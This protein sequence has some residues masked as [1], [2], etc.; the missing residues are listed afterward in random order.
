MPFKLK[1]AVLAAVTVLAGLL[2]AAPAIAAPP[3]PLGSMPTGT[4][5][6]H[7]TAGRGLGISLDAFGLTPGSAH[8]VTL[9]MAPCSATTGGAGVH[10]V[11]ANG[12]GQLQSAFR[13]SGRK[14][15]G[16]QSVSLLLGTPGASGGGVSPSKIVACANI[17]QPLQGF[18]QLPL[19][20]KLGWASQLS[21]SFTVTYDAPA[22]TLT[23][24]IDARGF[25]PGS[26]HAA[27]IHQGTCQAQGGVVYMLPDLVADAS[28]DIHAVRA[29]TGVT[30]PPPASG[31]YLNIHLGDSS[32]ILSGGN[33]TLAFQ[34]LLCANV[35][36]VQTAPG[37]MAIGSEGEHFLSIGQTVVLGTV[38]DFTFSST[39]SN[40]SGMAGGQQ[41]TFDVTADTYADLDGNGPMPAGTKINIHTDS[42]ALDSQPLGGFAQVGSAS[43]STEISADGQEVD[44]F[45]N[46]GVNWPA[47]AG[48][49]AHDCFAGY[50]GLATGVAS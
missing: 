28:G 27:H 13:V 37:A 32:Q 30:T 11:R 10:V 35:D 24:D 1:S 14:A 44:V 26:T 40:P 48:T 3:T 36:D 5:T 41:V 23:V 31:W 21:G 8:E 46:D 20:S 34:P 17:P 9:S 50:S 7:R 38:G 15:R 29:V 49:P 25:V 16:A 39:C 43:S 2:I 22:Q 33:P 47:G 12:S 19:K 6:L 42:D 4:V 18:V 45:Y